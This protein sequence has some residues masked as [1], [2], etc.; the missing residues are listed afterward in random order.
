MFSYCTSHKKAT[1]SEIQ[2]SDA[3]ETIN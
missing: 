1:N 2:H 3:A